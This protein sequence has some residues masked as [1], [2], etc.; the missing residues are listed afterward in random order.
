MRIYRRLWETN[1]KYFKGFIAISLLYALA[2]YFSSGFYHW[3][4]YFQILE[5]TAFKWGKTQASDLPWEFEARMR[6]WLQPFLLTPFKMFG[7]H[8]SIFLFRLITGQAFLYVLLHWYFLTK[9]K[10]SIKK[11]YYFWVTFLLWFFPMLLVR[12]SSENIS[13]LFLLAFSLLYLRDSKCPVQH[14]LMGIF[15]AVAF[16]CRFQVGVFLFFP[17]FHIIFIKR[18]WLSNFSLIAAFLIVCGLMVAIDS[19]GYGRLTFSPYEYFHQNIIL[20]KTSQ[21]GENAWWDYIKW[22]MTKP[23]P[24]VGL[25]IFFCSLYFFYKNKLNALAQ[26][27][28]IFI[29]IHQLIAH[30]E[31]RFLFPLIPFIP[32]VLWSSIEGMNVKSVFLKIFVIFNLLLVPSFFSSLHPIE[33]FSRIAPMGNINVQGDFRPDRL[34]GGLKATF[35]YEGQEFSEEASPFKFISKAGLLKEKLKSC[36]LLYSSRPFVDLQFKFK[37]L[38]ENKDLWSLIK[39]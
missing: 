7:P 19:W 16:W 29:V 31:L 23:T 2:A 9:E 4:E 37:T 18:R 17:L 36:E 6:P 3:D 21:F 28:F 38:K 33:E 24:L 35:F 20:K 39:C 15:A 1:P 5:F 26:G 11:P 22:I 27:M 13:S 14:T 8:F 10:F 34:A 30:K 32:L 12:Y 25:P